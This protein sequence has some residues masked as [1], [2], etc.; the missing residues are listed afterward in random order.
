[1]VT[2]VQDSTITNMGNLHCT[3]RARCR[4]L[5]VAPCDWDVVMQVLCLLRHHLGIQLGRGS[6]FVDL[7]SGLGQVFVAGEVL[8]VKCCW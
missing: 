2:C 6:L 3:A 1:M 7:G 4:V 5:H 8:L